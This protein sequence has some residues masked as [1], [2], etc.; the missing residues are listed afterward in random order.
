LTQNDS[1]EGDEATFDEV[2]PDLE[3]AEAQPPKAADRIP[4]QD[5]L[6]PERRAV[7]LPFTHFP[8]DHPLRK[9]ELALRIN[10]ATHLLAIIRNAVAEKSFQYSHIMR[11]APSKGVHTRS[12]AAIAKLKNQITHSCRVYN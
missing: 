6:A 12:R 7:V 10:Q 5:T 1:L 8:A 4:E 11:H 9:T 3:Q 2:D